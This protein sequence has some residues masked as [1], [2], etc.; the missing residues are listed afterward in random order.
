[1]AE[2]PALAIITTFADLEWDT[3]ARRM[4]E[5]VAEHLAP[6]IEFV[7][8]YEGARPDPIPERVEAVGISQVVPDL[9]DLI[10]FGRRHPQARGQINGVYD[11][12]FDAVRFCRKPLVVQ[13]MRRRL[14]HRSLIWLDADCVAHG[15]LDEAWLRRALPVDCDFSFLGR[16]G[17]YSE[18]GFLGFNPTPMAYE[19]I[20]RW[21]DQYRT[22]AV[23]K[24]A[25]W[26]D[27]WVFDQMRYQLHTEHHLRA[28]DLGYATGARGTHIFINSVLGE[29]LDHLKGPRK[30]LGR[31][32]LSD[33][34]K[35]RKEPYWQKGQGA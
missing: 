34:M 28:K 16:A 27:S 9:P 20:A 5:T 18:C 17:L 11:Y 19:L 33:L 2:A 25:Q 24:Q 35:P 31:S 15:A 10:A 29:R 21:A 4:V 13:G 14:P 32:N 30:K 6:T 1:M 3:Y 7:A 12:R 26:H 8:V 23:F 22:G